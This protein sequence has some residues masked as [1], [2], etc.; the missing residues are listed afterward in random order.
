MFAQFVIRVS[1]VFTILIQEYSAQLDIVFCNHSKKY[2]YN[3]RQ[4]CLELSQLNVDFSKSSKLPIF[5]NN[6]STNSTKVCS[7][8]V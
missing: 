4:I 8:A 1:G 5:K 2:C 7:I 3:F 6:N